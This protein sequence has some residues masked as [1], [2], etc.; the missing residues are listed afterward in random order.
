M[1]GQPDSGSQAAGL[2]FQDLILAAAK[3]RTAKRSASVTP[4]DS[5]AKARRLLAEVLN[6]ASGNSESQ[7]ALDDPLGTSGQDD[8]LGSWPSSSGSPSSTSILAL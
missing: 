5:S 3:A 7:M 4:L 8:P 1:D 2:S 6:V